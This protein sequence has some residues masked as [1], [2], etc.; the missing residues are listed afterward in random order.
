MINEWYLAGGRD[1][2]V[3]F[4]FMRTPQ[5]TG[6]WPASGKQT[7]PAVSLG[8]RPDP[9]RSALPLVNNQLVDSPSLPVQAQ[10]DRRLD[11]VDGKRPSRRVQN[12]LVAVGAEAAV[13][14]CSRNQIHRMQQ[15]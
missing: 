1:K 14:W 2:R 4:S 15:Q 6:T 12:D 5:S 11:F 3:R 8:L 9:P 7:A 10:I 13:T